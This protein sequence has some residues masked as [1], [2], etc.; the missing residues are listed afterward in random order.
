MISIA[1]I[2][3]PENGGTG[4]KTY[5]ILI[6]IPGRDANEHDIYIGTDFNDVNDANTSSDE[7][8]GRQPYEPH[9]YSEPGGFDVNTTYYWRID[10]VNEYEIWKGDV[11]TFTTEKCTVIDD[12]ESYYDT[13]ALRNTW[14]AGGNAQRWLEKD[15]NKVHGGQQSMRFTYSNDSGPYYSELT[16]TYYYPQD[17]T[18]E[19]VKALSLSFRGRE[20]NDANEPMYVR[21]SDTDSNE[22]VTY[23]D[24]GEDSNGLRTEEWQEW[25]ID[26]EDYNKAGVDLTDVSKITIGFGD[27]NGIESGSGTIYFDDIRLYPPRCVPA[28]AV[29][30]F[31]DD[32]LGDF[33][34]LEI[35][36][37]RWLCYDP[38]LID[39]DGD[40]EVAFPDFAILADK[41]LEEQLWP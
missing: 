4:F 15:P 10:E 7:Y 37:N 3:S 40:G 23:G 12:F 41:W 1:V 34:D 22:T 33:E 32:C 8:R 20:D 17:W 30:N 9:T 35:M 11:W 18:A 27:G 28:Y 29:G 38:V 31:T 2:V 5:I 14:A 19:G 26:L 13:T 21:I 36:A 39:P 6:W 24:Y 16:R 25:N